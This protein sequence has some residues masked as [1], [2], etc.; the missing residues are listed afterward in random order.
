MALTVRREPERDVC[1]SELQLQYRIYG[2][3]PVQAEGDV[4][5][6]PFY[7]RAR[8]EGWTFT[9]SLKN[10]VDPSMLNAKEFDNGMDGFFQ[11]E[12]MTGFELMGDYGYTFDASYMPYDVA[13]RLIEKSARKFLRD[14]EARQP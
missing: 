14:L 8:H 7:F 9:V 6:F 13:A 2:K 3:G 4:L 12:G 5:G 1:N 11:D 10:D